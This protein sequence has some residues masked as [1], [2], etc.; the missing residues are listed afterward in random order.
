MHIRWRSLLRVTHVLLASKSNDFFSGAFTGIYLHACDQTS[1]NLFEL[2]ETP[3][4]FG[5]YCGEGGNWTKIQLK[6]NNNN[7]ALPLRRSKKKY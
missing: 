3:F 1:L 2:R 4:G 7:M 5:L 6:N